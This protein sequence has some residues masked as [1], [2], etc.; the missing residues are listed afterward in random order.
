MP[1]FTSLANSAANGWRKLKEETLTYTP[2]SSERNRPLPSPERKL[3]KVNLLQYTDL[4][5]PTFKS[6]TSREIQLG[7]PQTYLRQCETDRFF[8][9]RMSSLDMADSRA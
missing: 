3:R 6:K 4:P 9:E 2:P 7:L 5:R 8:R 1:S